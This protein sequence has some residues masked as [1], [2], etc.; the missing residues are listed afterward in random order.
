[1]SYIRSRYTN[2]WDGM[3]DREYILAEFY[4]EN[5][6]YV[7]VEVVSLDDMRKIEKMLDYCTKLGAEQAKEALC[8]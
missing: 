6:P 8:K 7:S 1:M 5:A 3:H 4:F 2:C